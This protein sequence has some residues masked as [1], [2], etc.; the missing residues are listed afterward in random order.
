MTYSDEWLKARRAEIDLKNS[1]EPFPA[2]DNL[3]TT[4]WHNF[5]PYKK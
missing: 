5:V 1:L 4:E 3:T 2:A